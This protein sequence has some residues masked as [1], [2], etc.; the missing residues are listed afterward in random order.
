[1]P[2]GL[3]DAHPTDAIDDLAQYTGQCRMLLLKAHG[4]FLHLSAQIRVLIRLQRI[5]I[6]GNP[7]QQGLT[8][9][10]QLRMFSQ[11]GVQLLQLLFQLFGHD[12]SSL[13]T[14]AV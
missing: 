9:T 13:Q 14:T 8:F 6:G 4:L 3:P 12:I 10:V 7:L 5:N 11:R 1:L 2:P